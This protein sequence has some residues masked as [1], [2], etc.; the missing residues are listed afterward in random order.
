MSDDLKHVRSLIIVFAMP[1]CHHCHE[2]LPKLQRHVDNFKS[3]GVPLIYYANRPLVRGQIPIIVVDSTT[4]DPQIQS[5]LDQY[6]VEGMP[7]TV[8]WT[9]NARPRTLEGD[10][11]DPTIH[12]LL[13]SAAIASR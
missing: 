6:K 4:N 10:L 2:Y 5:M 8:L 9:W 11:D 13:T 1:G 3:H 7:T 12:E